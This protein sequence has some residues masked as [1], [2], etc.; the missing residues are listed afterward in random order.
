MVIFLLIFAAFSSCS[1]LERFEKK[2]LVIIGS[3]VTHTI[4]AELAR[5]E[6]QQSQGLMYRKRIKDGEGMLFISERD[7]ILSFWMKNTL[8]PLSIAY[9]ASD[10]RIFEIHDLQPGNLSSVVSSRS[11]RYALEVPQGWFKRAGIDVGDKIDL[12]GL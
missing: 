11:G 10:G 4:T 5:T 12:T 8:V 1:G 2:Q 7:R 9:I 3:G 6:A